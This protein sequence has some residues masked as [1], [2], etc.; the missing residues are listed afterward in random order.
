M[1]K[2]QSSRHGGCPTHRSKV[3]KLK[4]AKNKHG[5]YVTWYNILGAVV[6]GT[7]LKNRV[8]E[9]RGMKLERIRVEGTSLN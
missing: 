9:P 7:S 5:V 4:S 6:S 3:G 2:M 1:I 8:A